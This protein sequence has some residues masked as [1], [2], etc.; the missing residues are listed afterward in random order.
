M[1]KAELGELIDKKK[2]LH[3][4]RSY[5]EDKL[6]NLIEEIFYE[7]M[8]EGYELAKYRLSMFTAFPFHAADEFLGENM[9]KIREMLELCR[10]YE[11]FKET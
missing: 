11:N 6:R 4:I 5:D 8:R 7:G 10:Q 2:F 1:T 3:E 9:D